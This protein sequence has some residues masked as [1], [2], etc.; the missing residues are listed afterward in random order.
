MGHTP[1]PPV[2]GSAATTEPAACEPGST[3]GSQVG[4]NERAAL[5]VPTLDDLIGG[6]QL[7]RTRHSP[8]DA[9]PPAVAP[10]ERS[11]ARAGQVQSPDG[12]GPASSS[13]RTGSAE[14]H[15]YSCSSCDRVTRHHGGQASTCDFCGGPLRVL[16]G[17]G[18][19]AARRSDRDAASPEPHLTPAR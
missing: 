13:D 19:L 1:A 5:I 17:L 18:Q 9:E 12:V 2:L 14:P 3:L 4:R 11:Q 10:T 6:N 7:L 16:W 15:L 8:H